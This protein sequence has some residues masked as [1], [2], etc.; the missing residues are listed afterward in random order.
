MGGLNK[1]VRF[2]S[3]KSKMKT[4]KQFIILCI[5]LTGA[6]TERQISYLASLPTCT[7]ILTI[8]KPEAFYNFPVQKIQA[9]S[10]HGYN[11][12][13]LVKLLYY[14]V[15]IRRLVKI[16]RQNKGVAAVSFLDRANVLNIL[17]KPFAKHKC[18][19]SLRN[20]IVQM[21]STTFLKRVRLKLFFWL[22]GKADMLV[23]NSHHSLERYRQY[24]KISPAKLEFV[25]NCFPVQ[26]I[27]RKAEEKLPEPFD[28]IFANGQVIV[29]VGNTYFRKGH[30]YLIR[31][32]SALVKKEEKAKLVIVGDGD[33]YT[34]LVG[35]AKN[36][37][38]RV[39]D[40]ATSKAATAEDQVYFLGAQ[41]NPYAFMKRA[42][43]FALSSVVEG[44]PNALSE[45]LICATEVIAAD[46]FTGPK[47]MLAPELS[48]QSELSAP[49][50]TKFGYLMPS[51]EY[52]VI[53][54]NSELTT[55]EKY[56]VE[57][58]SR[59]L[60]NHKEAGHERYTM[61]AYAKKHDISFLLPKWQSLINREN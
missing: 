5:S 61:E 35:L 46:C 37:N 27:R 45:A 58:L 9:L 57:T 7:K 53:L 15:L 33:M 8:E 26:E 48:V 51:F 38:L 28:Q 49:Y 22:Y 54:E 24:S 3:L 18:I 23:F 34:K 60:R 16:L 4:D 14:P 20:D 32:F 41:K 25:E 43:V 56:W 30:W 10:K 17:A 42:K 36:L 1:T 19:I 2:H 47:E 40:R 50:K 6:G 39:Y 12:S 11:T 29:N 52:R 55:A 44:S 21:H 31:I 13:A 59:Q